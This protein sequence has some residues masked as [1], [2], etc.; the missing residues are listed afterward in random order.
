VPND[1][2]E[3]NVEDLYRELK[4][5][6]E[7]DYGLSF[8][9]KNSMFSFKI[10]NDITF[11]NLTDLNLHFQNVFIKKTPFLAFWLK[12]PARQTYHSVGVYPHDVQCPDGVLNIWTGYAVEKISP[13]DTDI[14]P[15]LNHL[16]IITKEDVMYEFLLDWLANMFQYPSSKSVMIVIQG[17][18]GSGKSVVCDLISAMMGDSAIEITDVK[19]NLFGR[20]NGILSRKVFVNINETDRKDM[21][22]FF[23]KMKAYITSPTITIE[24][25]G[26]KKYM[27]Q[28]LLHF[29][30]TSQNDNVFKITEE[31]RRYAY[32]ETSNELCGNTE[33]FN[34]LFMVVEKKSSQRAF[35]DFLMNR[36]V[37]RKLTIKDIP[38]TEAMRQQFVLNRDPIEDYAIQFV[39]ELTA[40]ENYNAYKM[41]IKNQGLQYEQSKKLF[42]MRFNKIMGKYDIDKTRKIV[43][44]IKQ[45][46]YYKP[47]DEPT[48]YP[49]GGL[50]LLE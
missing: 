23:E 34:D 14:E 25:K 46:I 37:K 29:I 15:I 41:F 18:E 40:Q 8:I 3:D 36:P 42:E 45:V 48:G 17:Q 35:Y 30:T 21:N 4:Q 39:D 47:M 44:G 6:Y 9:E 13:N 22:A 16:K 19:E 50:L 28:S 32:F 5:K 1:W 12:D 24:E 38:I 11:L 26:Q 20:F 31:S 33:Y 27:E 49:T 43:D 7:N 10:N 2:T